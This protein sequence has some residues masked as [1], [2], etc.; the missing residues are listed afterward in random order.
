MDSNMNGSPKYEIRFN[1][2][3]SKGGILPCAVEGIQYANHDVERSCFSLFK[4]GVEVRDKNY[5]ISLI[6]DAQ[7][8]GL[9]PHGEKIVD[10]PMDHEEARFMASLGIPKNGLPPGLRHHTNEHLP[11]LTIFGTP[12][13]GKIGYYRLNVALQSKTPHQFLQILVFFIPFYDALS[14]KKIDLPNI[15]FHERSP[16]GS[17]EIDPVEYY[18]RLD[19]L[20]HYSDI[21]WIAGRMPAGSFII[22]PGKSKDDVLAQYSQDVRGKVGGAERVTAAYFWCDR[23]L[24]LL[25][26]GRIGQHTGD[27]KFVI[28]ARDHARYHEKLFIVEIKLS[29]VLVRLTLK[30]CVAPGKYAMLANYGL[31]EG[32]KVIPSRIPI[33][34]E[35]EIL[36][37]NVP[38]EF[39]ANYNNA[40]GVAHH[41]SVGEGNKRLMLPAYTGVF[42]ANSDG[43]CFIGFEATVGDEKNVLKFS[44]KF[45]A[46]KVYWT[47]LPRMAGFALNNFAVTDDGYY[48]VF[49]P[50]GW[51]L[52]LD[53]DSL[54]REA[55]VDGDPKNSVVEGDLIYSIIDLP[56]RAFYNTLYDSRGGGFR[57]EELDLANGP[58]SISKFPSGTSDE[59]IPSYAPPQAAGALVLDT[60]HLDRIPNVDM[61]VYY[62]GKPVSWSPPK[63]LTDK[64]TGKGYFYCG[65]L[66]PGVKMAGDQYGIIGVPLKKGT[67]RFITAAR[68]KK[69]SS[70]SVLDS[71]VMNTVHVQGIERFV[72]DVSEFVRAGEEL[73]IDLQA[74]VHD[75]K[76]NAVKLKTGWANRIKSDGFLDEVSLHYDTPSSPTLT[77]RAGKLSRGVYPIYLEYSDSEVWIV[78][79]TVLGAGEKVPAERISPGD[80]NLDALESDLEFSSMRCDRGGRMHENLLAK[81]GVVGGKGRPYSLVGGRLPRGCQIDSD[82]D[83]TGVPLEYGLFSF[84]ISATRR[85]TEGGAHFYILPILPPLKLLPQR[86]PAG[87]T[88]GGK[89]SVPFSVTGAEGSPTFKAE[90]LQTVFSNLSIS[91]DGVL[92]FVPIKV[93]H[94]E[95]VI[96]VTDAKGGKNFPYQVY[97]EGRPHVRDYRG[98]L[99]EGQV[100][101]SI[102]DVSERA[103]GGPFISGHVVSMSDPAA[104]EKWD[105]PSEPGSDGKK[106]GFYFKFKEDYYGSVHIRYTLSNSLVVSDEGTIVLVRFHA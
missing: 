37:E 96:G 30:A 88:V 61:G 85:G 102:S 66:P 70:S 78:L 6:T 42:R 2:L 50:P 99:F 82:G 47:V 72:E 106:L 10:T 51:K 74:Y 36:H 23:R 100:E 39:K 54:G 56:I 79:V 104:C 28:R 29:I 97:I 67:Y 32:V 92:T 5:S 19:G 49:C 43:M 57:F 64:I 86:L 26:N 93:G 73:I 84:A 40:E 7:R 45:H 12:I 1:G 98:E 53:L 14:L 91:R 3:V 21:E 58:L 48:R 33:G 52:D 89:F 63:T 55:V 44:I 94:F 17:V 103:V 34:F 71:F 9:D 16:E 90:G 80:W 95:L 101:Y 81:V 59:Q 24:Q 38:I 46:K 87:A 65:D 62:L 13:Q 20:D 31:K 11:Q 60:L 69:N 41:K 77:V 35:L 75:V 76:L 25:E 83:I 15:L 18:Q 22:N 8:E 27:F 68:D 105:F 4:D